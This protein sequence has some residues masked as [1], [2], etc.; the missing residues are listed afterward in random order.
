LSLTY[1]EMELDIIREIGNDLNGSLFL[2]RSGGEEEISIATHL[3]PC[4]E[5]GDG[6]D[7]YNKWFGASNIADWLKN[8][9]IPLDFV[10]GEGSACEERTRYVNRF[11]CDQVNHLHLAD[12]SLSASEVARIAYMRVL[13]L[14]SGLYRPF[15]NP[16]VWNCRY[17]DAFI[18]VEGQDGVSSLPNF[19]IR[20]NSFVEKNDD[21]G[22][23]HIGQLLPAQLKQKM[24]RLNNNLVCMT[25]YIFRA[26]GHHYL[27]SFN[28]KL[29]S[30]FRK[31]NRDETF[32]D[33]GLK[34]V[35]ITRYANHAI[36]PALLDVF[37]LWCVNTSRCDNAL[38][39][40]VN[41]PPAGMAIISGA[42]AA[43]QDVEILFG[44]RVETFRA[45]QQEVNRGLAAL[46]ANRW[47]GGINRKFYGA[48]DY[49]VDESK[50]AAVAATVSALLKAN[51]S[52]APILQSNSLTRAGNNAPLTGTFIGKLLTAYLKTPDAVQNLLNGA[53]SNRAKAIEAAAALEEG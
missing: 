37:W 34:W 28:E 20:Q 45:A 10:A 4:R 11:F 3:V 13:N 16:L 26:R 17:N 35:H 12:P 41:V 5:P 9:E 38:A 19:S 48:P 32:A 53:V 46:A 6:L 44:A 18:A 29:D 23:T 25:A 39:L 27:E 33:L 7:D 36:F 14:F 40:R 52:N 47:T 50:L 24:I 1:L 2:V 31:C 42:Q 51:S 15:D 8:Q 30:L 21:L 43:L 22:F 49:Q